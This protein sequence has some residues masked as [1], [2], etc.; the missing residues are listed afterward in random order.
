MVHLG[1]S[2]EPVVAPWSLIGCL[3]CSENNQYLHAWCLLHVWV[4]LDH[5]AY[6]FSSCFLQC[7]QCSNIFCSFP[8]GSAC[9]FAAMW[10]TN[11]IVEET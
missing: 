8:V 5:S 10:T 11:D 3:D 9:L 4:Q 7:G 6:V 2:F 1:A